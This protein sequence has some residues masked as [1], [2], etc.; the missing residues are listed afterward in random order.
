MGNWKSRL[1]STVGETNLAATRG[2][3]SG[4]FNVLWIRDLGH[5]PSNLQSG[6]SGPDSKLVAP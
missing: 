6:I 2:N 1:S 3:P 4:R 5:I